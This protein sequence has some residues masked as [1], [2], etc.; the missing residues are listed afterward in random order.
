[1][2]VLA[3]FTCTERRELT[4]TSQYASADQVPAPGPT[5]VDVTLRACQR[6]SENPGGDNVEW[7]KYTPSGELTMVITNPDAFGQFV[8]GQ[9]YFL[10]IR[11]AQPR[12]SRA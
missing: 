2:A 10:E 11:K 8:V 7:S 4:T 9:D 1:M 6:S 12:K 3:K 5:Q